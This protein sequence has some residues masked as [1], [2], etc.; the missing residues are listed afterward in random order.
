MA[1]FVRLQQRHPFSPLWEFYVDTIMQ[2]SARRR[3]SS[4]KDGH[5][6]TETFDLWRKQ[7]EFRPFN[8]SHPGLNN[9]RAGHIL[10]VLEAF[11]W[12]PNGGE[13]K[14]PDWW[15]QDSAGLVELI[16][17]EREEMGRLGYIDVGARWQAG[18]DEAPN[19]RPAAEDEAS[20]S[21]SAS[22]LKR[23]HTE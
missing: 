5:I 3:L 13:R 11:R 2:P 22:P 20:T 10:S 18:G 9:H 8:L 17:K 7:V 21:G 1:R 16:E 6:A 15:P 12:L 23:K 14:R 4:Y 19:T